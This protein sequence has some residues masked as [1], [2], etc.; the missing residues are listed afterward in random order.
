MLIWTENA[1]SHI[2]EFIKENRIDKEQ[3]AKSYMNKLVDYVDS[4]D[5]KK[6]KRDID[7]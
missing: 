1:I 3:T 5:K 4:L 2:T 7:L 6:S